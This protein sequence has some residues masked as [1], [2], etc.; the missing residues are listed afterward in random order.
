MYFSVSVVPL[1]LCRISDKQLK[2]EEFV[3]VKAPE[4]SQTAGPMCPVL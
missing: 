2:E 4:A 3:V 1:W